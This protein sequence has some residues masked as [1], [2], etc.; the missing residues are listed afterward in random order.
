MELT[1]AMMA[2]GAVGISIKLVVL[3]GS[4]LMMEASLLSDSNFL[5]IIHFLIQRSKSIARI[6]KLKISKIVSMLTNDWELLEIFRI[7]I[8]MFSSEFPLPLTGGAAFDW[9]H[10]IPVRYFRIF[11]SR[12]SALTVIN[13]H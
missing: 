1:G 11:R 10:M 6:T 4:G 8:L 3:V 12:D 7:P 5:L 9:W 13:P 2:R